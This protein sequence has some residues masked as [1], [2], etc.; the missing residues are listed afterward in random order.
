MS[1]K[2]SASINRRFTP[3]QGFQAFSGAEAFSDS[4]CYVGAK[5]LDAADDDLDFLSL[6]ASFL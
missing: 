5:S 6:A 3:Q 2:D 1:V 4:D